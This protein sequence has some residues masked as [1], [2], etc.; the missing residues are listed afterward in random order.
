MSIELNQIGTFTTGVFDESAAE[1]AAFDPSSQR[2]F[3]VNGDSNAIDVLD[4]SDPTNPTPIASLDVSLSGGPNSV[5][6]ANG[7]VAVALEDVTETETGTV[8]FFNAADLSLSN[9]V[10]VGVLPDA[11][12]FTPDGTKLL[13]ANEGEPVGDGNLLEVDPEGTISI[14][15]LSAGVEEATVATA[16]FSAFNGRENDLRG[17]GV[18]I[19]PGR[20]AAQDLE[21]EFIAVSPDGTTAFVTLQENNAVAVVDIE[22]ATVLDILPLGVTDFS[23]GLPELET[24]D[25][26]ELTTESFQIGTDPDGNPIFLGGLSGLAFDGFNPDN[27]NPRFV[28]INDRG[29]VGGALD[30]PDPDSSDRPFFAPELQVTVLTL[31]LDE[32]SGQVSIVDSLGLTREI[33]VV[34]VPFPVSVPLT[35]LPN[36]PGFFEVPVDPETGDPLPNDFFG[37][38]SE[39][40]IRD[41]ST[42]NLYIADEQAPSINVFSS[43]GALID[44]FVPIGFAA[45]DETGSPAGTFGSETL[46]EV[47]L[48]RRNNRGFEG[49]AFDTERNIVYGF[50]QTPLSNPDT[51]TS[52]GSSILRILGIDPVTGVPIEEFVYVLQTPALVTTDPSTS[53][54]SAE[55][56]RIGDAVFAGD[57]QFYV[58]ERDNE[59]IDTAQ[60]FI[61]KI[62]LQ[63]A[64]NILGTDIANATD[65]ATLETLSPDDLAAAGIQPVNKIQVTNLPS[66]GF[67]PS[68]QSEGLAL[69][70]DGRLAVLNDNDYEGP[71]TPTQLGII[72][73][74]SSN[75]L[76][77]S[78][79]DGAINI[80][81]FPVF[82]LFQPD[83]IASFE[84]DGQTF[85][86]T[87]NEGDGRDSFDDLTDI[88]RVGDLTLDPDAFP[89]A[90]T[91]QLDEN[92][93]RLEV[94]TI[95]GDIDGDGDFDQ[96]FAFGSRSFSIR[97]A[98][99]NIVFDSGDQLEQITAAALPED[100]NSD[101]DEN[102]S[103]DSRSDDGGPEPEG[104]AVGTVGDRTFAFIGLERIGGIAV[105]D[106]SDPANSSFV[107][108]INNRDFSL[109]LELPDGS[110]N[111]AAG[112]SGPEGLV[113]ISAEDSPNGNPL[114]VVANEVSGSTTIFE[115]SDLDDPGPGGAIA[116]QA[117]NDLDSSSTFTTDQLADGEPLTNA[118]SVN[119]GGPGLDFQTFFFETRGAAGPAAGTESGDFIGVN[120]FIGANAPDVAADG[121]PVAAGVEHNFQFNDGD[122]RLDLVFESVDLTDIDQSFL[123]FDYWINDTGFEADDAFSFSLSDG[124]HS[125][126]FLNFGEAELEANVS[127]DDG[128]PNWN[129][130]TVDL[131]ELINTSGFDN[132]LTLTLSV[133]TNS[134][135]ENIFVDNILFAEGE[136]PD[137][138]PDPVTV[139]AIYEIQGAGHL[140]PLLGELVQTTGIVTAIAFNGFYL[141]DAVGDGDDN[142]SDGIFVAG[143]TAG[144][145]V[146]HE[147]EVEGTVAEIIPGG[148]GTGNLSITQLNASDISANSSGNALPDAVVIGQSGRL[149]ANTTV[150]SDDELPV[151]LQNAADDVA[152]NFDPENDAIDF[153][154][155]LEGQRVTI[156]AAVAVS[157]TRVFTPFSA[158]AFTLPNLGATSDDP[159]NSRGG[160]NLDSGPDNLGD[161]NPER[162]QIQ[163]DP[164]ISGE[165]TP[166][167]LN[168]GD[169]LG[170]VTGVVGY[171]FGNFEV[172]LTGPVNVVTPSGL[173]QEVTDLVGT[174][175]Q[176]TV[177]SYNVLNLTST[178]ADE[179]GLDPDAAQRDR[180]AAQIIDNLGSPDIIALQEIQ[181]N[182]GENGGSNS[183]VSDA[184]QTLQDLVDAIAAAGGPTYQFFDVFNAA[185]VGNEGEF[186]ELQGGVPGGNI[187]NAFLYNPDRVTLEGMDAL[188]PTALAAAGVSNPD[189]FAGSRVPVVGTFGFNGETV[190]VVN[191]HFSSRFGSTPIFGGPQPFVQAGEAAREAQSLA[192][193]EFV[194]SLLA[195]D[196][197]ANIVVAGDLNTF[198]FTNDL[199]EILPGTGDERVL[200]NLISQAEADGDA[201]TFIFDGNSQVL[202][203]FFVTDSIL[204]GAEFDIV[205]VNNDFTRD[206]DA[207]EFDDVLPASDHEP[208]VARLDLSADPVEPANFTLQL[209]HASDLEGGVDAI[210]AAPNFAALVS[211][212]EA[213]FEN[214]ITLSAG[215]NFIS[216]PFFNAASDPNAFNPIFE[217][218][219]NTIPIFDVDGDGT[220]AALVDVSAIPDSADTDGNSFL[221]NGEID[222]FLLDPTQNTAGLTAADVYVTDINGDGDPDFFDEI[223]NFQGRVDI[224]I[225]NLI[226]FDASALGNHEFDLGTDTLENIINYD[227][228]EG[229]SLSST[230]EASILAAFPD[231]VNFLQEV[232]FPGIQFPYLSSNLDFSADPEIGNLFTDE[233][234]LSTEF[235]SDL[236]SARA[237]PADPFETAADSNDDRIAPSTV[238]EVGGELIGVV[239]ATTPLLESISSPGLVEVLPSSDAIAELA[240]IIQTEIDELLAFD[241]GSGRSLDKVILVSHLQQFAIEAEQL[242]P[243]LSGVDIIVAGG[244]DQIVADQ[245]DIDRGLQPGDTIDNVFDIDPDT[246]SVQPGYPFVTS[247]AD[248]NPVAVV[249]TDGEYSY[250]GRLAIE[251]D[252]NGNIIP[253]SVDETV[254]G[255]FATTDAGVIAQFNQAGALTDAEA[256]EAAFAD[257]TS[258][259]VVQDL[260]NNVTNVVNLQ[261]GNI[262]GQSDVFLNGARSSVRN[263]ETNFG[264]LTADANIFVAREIE[265]IDTSPI[266]VSIK[267]GGGI[268]DII[269]FVGQLDD[270]TVVQT[271]TQANPAAGKEAGDVSQLDIANTLRF[272]NGLELVTLTSEQ[273]LEVLEHAVAESQPDMFNEPGQFG[274]VGNIRF[275]FDPTQ[276]ARSFD[277]NTLEQITAG[278]RI[279]NVTV[280]DEATGEFV[281]VV[282]DGEVL[283]NAPAA[284]RVVTLDFLENG[285]DS[286][287]FPVFEALDP[288]FY[289]EVNLE[290]EFAALA[291]GSFQDLADFADAGSEQD[292]LAELFFAEFNEDLGGSAFG[293]EDTSVSEDERVQNLSFREDTVL[294]SLAV[295]IGTDGDDILQGTADGDSIFGLAGDDIIKGRAGD[296]ELFGADGDDFLKGD[297][298]NDTL[299]GGAGDDDLKAG[300]GDD[301]L[302]G[303]GGNDDLFGRAGDDT[304]VGG[305]G[306][307]DLFGGG[308]A[309]TLE[310]GGGNDDLRA[311]GGAD[312]LYGGEGDD[313][314]IGGGGADTL[315]GG[316]GNDDL[317]GGGGADFIAG[318]SGSD[319]LFGNGGADTLMGGGGS[320]R[321]NGGGGNDT[322]D[323]SD[324]PV[325]VTADLAAGTAFY[326]PAPDVLITDTLR[327]I[328][329]LTGTVFNDNLAGDARANIL[330]GVGG[331][332]ALTGGAGGDTFVLGDESGAF[333]AEAGTADVAELTDFATGEDRIQLSGSLGD[334]AFFSLG[335][336]PATAIALDDGNGSFD[337]LGD[338]LVAFVG[339]GF[340]LTDLAFV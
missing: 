202:D 137:V 100:F 322:A 99:G 115:I 314:L 272:N 119:S 267:N 57:G 183:L 301:D 181:D 121:T 167:A 246:P 306:D 85:F 131:D 187:R 23:R 112:D 310:G 335:S 39:G 316:S 156:E 271:T 106:I 190:M 71:G 196:P 27:G 262:V 35:G 65:G 320:D 291:S 276:A 257:G 287:P 260:V 50:I 128:T 307:D 254:S 324:I 298:G 48:N 6:V 98:L 161:R 198:Q 151:N 252:S 152:N 315:M 72:S 130:V 22:S 201:Y 169:Q 296:D 259:Q 239:G 294:P 20:T 194:D 7:I 192:N 264:N 108:Y 234:L 339:N 38:D 97:D 249:S 224:T 47:Y 55:V 171:S 269:G 29:P 68:A 280:F 81:N 266:L 210:S 241:D 334:Y 15:D 281:P 337:F 21:P 204:E 226:G 165:S 124:T 148:A 78:D 184:S 5:A 58:I 338:E 328:E 295:L 141:Q 263:E 265:D 243:L 333:Y 28:A 127:P 193:N 332:D 309:D 62:D 223:D 277:P 237:N 329:N 105:F 258:Q 282:V 142:T 206:D 235:A 18:R 317:F 232:D 86:I 54:G 216:G 157:P 77:P 4:L 52:N 238:I 75:G 91:L 87:A 133:D 195:T 284:I 109:D 25:I 46:P 60:Q 176:L 219:Y 336:G 191:N 200:T 229:N 175:D 36:I 215:D 114:L 88:D 180:L 189:A 16:D 13:V 182:D 318:G 248:G 303:G 162:V 251:F 76:D 163:F 222:A 63:G 330:N 53:F 178:L 159:L 120:S 170:D 166:P 158:E 64:T 104:I 12:T 26:P 69:L 19:F 153:Y 118:G 293:V 93:G 285:G 228:E 247:D 179:G 319:D 14:I 101:N 160:I 199:V 308:G 225:M 323:F 2:L 186:T 132:E 96:L 40:I 292:A 45:Q 221:D 11:V 155:S 147:V 286:Y 174:E 31:E 244:S 164:T 203:N 154:E 61:F 107:Q 30:T 321:L 83:T 313:D 90:D 122:G 233:I 126:T 113:F 3:V 110:S 275:S 212:F 289:N 311:G 197:A 84:I 59:D 89:D 245:E 73:F 80:D 253:E 283:P 214:T 242:A 227:S 67:S 125:Q 255:A 209:L 240:T 43:E 140:S 94:S 312:T 49:I 56:D 230:G 250:V 79:D 66:L 32:A 143:S 236:L 305:E 256:L 136:A 134:G 299:L 177:A 172:N 145:A 168:V 34:G 274:Q 111:P 270:G 70:S 103:F 340:E 9:V 74:E 325:G 129:T 42:G 213:E 10:G 273:L 261:D 17:D 82:G 144:I 123:S 173:E 149:P 138:D 44:R 95:D 217:G 51:A 208:L 205:H 290:A 146:G 117:F 8:A 92:L 218:L 33:S 150:I 279:L 207:I 327:S 268:R 278:D 288:D 116:A 300:Q 304:L 24:F 331:A 302:Q 135:V 1:I 220:P 102:G 185:G 326:E 41:P 231:L 37:L 211:A 139:A 188:T 297:S